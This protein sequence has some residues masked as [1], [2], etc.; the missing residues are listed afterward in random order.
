MKGRL[1][2]IQYFINLLP[3]IAGRSTCIK[4]QVGAV[5]TKE[6]NLVA[7]G[8]NGAPSGCVHC[9][10]LGCMRKVLK[11]ES[12]KNMELCRGA[13]AEMNAICQAAKHGISLKDADIYSYVFPCSWCMKM[14]INTGIKNIYYIEDYMDDL[15]KQL[16]AE[17]SIR[18]LKVKPTVKYFSAYDEKME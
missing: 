12:G 18:C 2:H 13:H 16:A 17:A 14:I 4:R 1:S 8:Y 11:I 7:T 9:E 5:I 10:E 3:L 6:N 15:S